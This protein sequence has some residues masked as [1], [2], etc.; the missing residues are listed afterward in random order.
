VN[1]DDEEILELEA[2]RPGN[3]STSHTLFLSEEPHVAPK[4]SA[5]THIAPEMSTPARNPQAKKKAR[6]GAAGKRQLATG[7]LLA[8]LLDDVSYLSL[9]VVFLVYSRKIQ[10][11]DTIL[12]PVDY[13]TAFNEGD[14]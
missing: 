11:L 6:T 3:T 10:L 14:G 1:R 2:P 9:Y 13:F 4:T 8:P 7:S 5:P 12:L